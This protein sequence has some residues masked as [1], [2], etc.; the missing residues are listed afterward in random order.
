MS[1]THAYDFLCMIFD[2]YRSMKRRKFQKSKKYY[3]LNSI[4]MMSIVS[5]FTDIVSGI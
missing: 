1:N 4:V 2:D 3:S 5:I